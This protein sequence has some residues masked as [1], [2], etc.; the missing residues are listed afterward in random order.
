MDPEASLLT[1]LLSTGTVVIGGGEPHSA[2]LTGTRALMYAVFEEA[3]RDYRCGQPH[4]HAQAEAWIGSERRW[5]FSFVVVCET[6]GFEPTA[7]RR[8]LR[9]WRDA[10]TQ[11][12]YPERLR[13]YARP[14]MT[15]STM[16]VA[17]RRRRSVRTIRRR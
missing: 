8:A 10:R 11:P 17:H 7:V 1:Q 5:P 4:L 12:S 2:E 9:R 3:L 6:L 16:S 13:P 14:R 15:L